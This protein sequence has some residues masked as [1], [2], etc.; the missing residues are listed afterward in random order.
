MNSKQA[1]DMMA[2]DLNAFID[3]ST[4]DKDEK[5]ETKAAKLQAK[6]TAE[7]DLD[8]T[9][10]TRD[11]DTKYLED[12]TATC[13]EKA[14]AFASRQQLRPEEIVAIEKAIEIISSSSVSG[15]ADK[16]L[17]ALMQKSSFAQLR[18]DTRSSAQQRAAAFLQHQ[19]EQSS[20]RVLAA[21]AARVS[22]DP[23]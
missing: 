18:V 12:L 14:S 8:D 10:T 13:E 7:G 21:L 22:D 15:A 23:F 4:K 1:F 2:M 16:H 5:S 3:S 19:A 20:S 17:P 11:A 9:T 6:A